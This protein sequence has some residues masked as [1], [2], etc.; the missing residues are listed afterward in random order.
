MIDELKSGLQK[1][2]DITKMS[3]KDISTLKACQSI[4]WS[5]YHRFGADIAVTFIRQAIKKNPNC[6]MWYFILAKNLRRKRRDMTISSPPTKEEC[7]SFLKAYQMSKNPIY[8]IFVAQMYRESHK[9]NKALQIYEDVFRMEPESITVIL[10]MALGF[11]Q[12]RSFALAKKCLNE[13]A[14]RCPTHSMYLHYHAIFYL[15]QNK[16]AVRI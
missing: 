1:I 4:A 7:E 2:E 8:G 11:T 6:D 5:K 14:E 12:L 16:F 9:R 15:K 10:R 3:K 13:A